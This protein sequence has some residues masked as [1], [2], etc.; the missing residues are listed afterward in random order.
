MRF[1][2]L[3]KQLITYVIILQ[4]SEIVKDRA[5][6]KTEYFVLTGPIKHHTIS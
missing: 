5:T 1:F 3:E 2:Q 4:F 6:A